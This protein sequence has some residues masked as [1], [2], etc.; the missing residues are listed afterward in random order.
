MC[1]RAKLTC[2]NRHVVTL[3]SYKDLVQKPKKIEYE[4]RKKKKPRE[5][6]AKNRTNVQIKNK[7]QTQKM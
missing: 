7:K 4:E 2:E 3:N 6:K 1:V 5:Q